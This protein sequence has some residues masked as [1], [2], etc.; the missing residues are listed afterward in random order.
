MPPKIDNEVFEWLGEQLEP[1]PATKPTSKKKWLPR[2]TPKQRE[3]FLAQEK[4]IL[5]HGPK[6]GAKTYGVLDKLVRHCFDNRN[7]LALILVRVQNMAVKGG[8]WDKLTSEVLPRWRDG[9][10][11]PL[12]VRKNGEWVS[13]PKAGEKMD[14]GLGLNYTEVKFDANHCPFIWIQNKHGGWSLITVMSCPHAN[15]LRQRIRG[16]EPSIV[17]LDEATSCDT[18]EYFESVAAQLGRRPQVETVQQ[19]LAATNP[20]DPDHWVYLKW[21]VEPYDADTGAKNP[22]FR[23]IYF[24]PD[25]NLE[26]LQLGYL[27]GLASVYG[28]NA[29]EAARMIGGEWVSAPS[30][31]A[32]FKDLFNIAIHVRPLDDTG[33]PSTSEWLMPDPNYAMILGLDPGSVYNAFIFMQWLPIDGIFRWMHFDE[34][35][36]LRKRVKYPDLVPA[37]MRRIR[38]WRDVTG[39]EIPQVWISDD[40]AFNVFRAATGSFDALDIQKV[41]EANREKYSLEPMRIRPCPKF[42]GSVEARI[43]IE[44]TA[45]A[46]DEII[47]S[48]RCVHVRRMYEKLE[49]EKQKAGAPFDPRL[50]T[51]PRRSDHLHVFDAGSYPKLAAATKPTLLQPIRS[52]GGSSLI[53]VGRQA[54]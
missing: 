52:A 25:D 54:A 24:P 7:A 34:I 8:S 40:T 48:S 29:T 1:P 32:L 22:N 6:G 31:E 5:C 16:V 23:D 49:S 3:L 33:R 19:F 36:L 15:Q 20:E 46:Q 21:F 51:T 44:Q 50:A 10:I 45:L 12:N 27:E 41:Y 39:A 13:N 17:F 43:R 18:P 38:F 9:N 30:G 4:Y 42:Q 2:H 28:K 26:N 35:V 11:Q 14:D 47:V 37:V 53:S